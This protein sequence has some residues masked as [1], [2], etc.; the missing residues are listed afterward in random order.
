[1]TLSE[2]GDACFT[3][4]DEWGRI[5]VN[6]ML[7]DGEAIMPPLS[8]YGPLMIDGTVIVGY[9]SIVYD[10]WSKPGL[11]VQVHRR[12]LLDKVYIDMCEYIGVVGIEWEDKVSDV[13]PGERTLI[14]TGVVELYD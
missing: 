13:I 7:E 14:V 9:H 3:G 10:D 2:Y 5:V 12:S 8:I 1:M 4:V 11:P 6:D